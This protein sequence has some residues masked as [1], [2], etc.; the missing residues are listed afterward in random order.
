MTRGDDPPLVP[1][2]DLVALL[3]ALAD[4]YAAARECRESFQASVVA[5]AHAGLHREFR[6]DEDRR[7]T[8]SP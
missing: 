6:W 8:P 5:R 1:E 4:R 7:L 3:A 2:A